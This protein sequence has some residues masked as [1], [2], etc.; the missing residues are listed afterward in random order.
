M[1]KQARTYKL[2]G[3]IPNIKI[4]LMAII[5]L[6]TNSKKIRKLRNL[7]PMKICISINLNIILK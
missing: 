3:G 7:M 5:D 6:L 4:D 2:C 1:V